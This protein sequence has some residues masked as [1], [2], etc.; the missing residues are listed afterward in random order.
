M[1]GLDVE[2]PRQDNE[3][4]GGPRERRGSDRSGG[5]GRAAGRKVRFG[6]WDRRTGSDRNSCLQLAGALQGQAGP[7]AALSRGL[8]S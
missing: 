5:E 6:R 8:G 1:V 7:C 4:W 3:V 2:G